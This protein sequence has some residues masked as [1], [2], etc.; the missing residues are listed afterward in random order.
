MSGTRS[1][2]RVPGLVSAGEI[3]RVLHVRLSVADGKVIVF[4]LNIRLISGLL[5]R[6][7]GEGDIYPSPVMQGD[8]STTE[9]YSF[10]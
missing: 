4:Q 5:K 6:A 1:S 3:D 9:L 7:R 2:K 10:G 8:V